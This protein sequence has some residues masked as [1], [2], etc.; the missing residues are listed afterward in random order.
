[1][2][3]KAETERLLEEKMERW[4]YLEDLAQRIE[5]VSYTHLYYEDG[6]TNKLTD[7]YVSDVFTKGEAFDVTTEIQKTISGY[8]WTRCDQEVYAGVID[9]NLVFNV[10]YT[11]RSSGNHNRCV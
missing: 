3:Q 11:R 5:A 2:A 8:N 4:M 10:Y 1:M 7:S 9:G 6:T